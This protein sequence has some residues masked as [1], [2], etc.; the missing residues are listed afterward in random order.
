MINVTVIGFGNVGASLALLLLNNQHSIRL[1]I[2]EPNNQ[3]EGAFLD[4]A[5]GMPLYI[6][7]E[8]FINDDD[9]FLDADFIFYS[10]GI[11]NK[12]GGSRLSTAKENIN[13]TKSVFKNRNFTKSPTLL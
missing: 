8:L 12:H 3:R 1:N 13:I 7:K 6:N 2:L 5:H 4:L 10:A 11:P 9:L